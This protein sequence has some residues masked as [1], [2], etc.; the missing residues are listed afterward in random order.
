M[1]GTI[2]RGA[3]EAADET[4]GVGEAAR[5]VE[6]VLAALGSTRTPGRNGKWQC[7]AHARSGEHAPS[8]AVGTREDTGGAWVVCF[9]GCTAREIAHA[10]GAT[11]DHLGRPP[12]LSATAWI[13]T[14]RLERGFPAPK[15]GGSPR[16]QGYRHEAFHSYGPGFRKERLRHPVTGDKAIEW[17]RRNDKGEWVWGLPEHTRPA[18]LPLYREEDLPHALGAGETV[19]LVESESTVDALNRAG[20]YA[21]T[22]AGGAGSPPLERLAV[23]LAGHG[24]HVVIGGDADDPGRACVERIGEVLPDAA[25]LFSDCAGEDPRDLLTRLGP[26]EFTTRVRATQHATIR[27]AGPARGAPS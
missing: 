24:T 4:G 7:P 13:R 5:W 12:R 18:D 14:R 6:E 25:V 10:L 11:L 20:W 8:L 23:L 15:A 19:L 3:A 22:W 2:A 27:A 17:Q 16:S 21:V 9:A 26:D 1:T